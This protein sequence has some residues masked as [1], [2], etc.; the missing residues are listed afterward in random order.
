MVLDKMGGS[1][2]EFVKDSS[3]ESLEAAFQ[4][5]RHRF[6]TGE[7]LCSLLAGLKQVVRRRGSLEACVAS[8]LPDDNGSVAA[9]LRRLVDELCAS[10]SPC[11]TLLPQPRRGS[12]CKRLNLFLRW[13]V[14]A[15]HVDPGGWT[16]VSPSA[17]I[18]PL[19]VHMHRLARSFGMTERRQA[20]MRA[21][22]EVTAGFREICPD[23]PT[24]Y[25][26][27]LTRLGMLERPVAAC[28][29]G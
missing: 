17:L 20:D 13:M 27:A 9:G 3:P 12:A 1:P 11:S 22:Q 2:R 19:D 10:G 23:D 8:G 14:R 6:S 21:A 16:S 5:F 18:V 26:F 7:E 28:V 29:G 25:D 24:R 15:D 4:D